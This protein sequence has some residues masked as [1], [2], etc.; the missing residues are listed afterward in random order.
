MFPRVA[1]PPPAK[2]AWDEFIER[3]EKVRFCVFL[4]ILLY[5]FHLF[6]LFSGISLWNFYK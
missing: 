4:K 2:D 3:K 6:G 1:A 5:F